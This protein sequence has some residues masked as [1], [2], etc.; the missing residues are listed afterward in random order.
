MR[1][2][3]QRDEFGKFLKG[4]G[5]GAS[6]RRK[7]PRRNRK[8]TAKAGA[9]WPKAKEETFFRELAMVC[10]VSSAWRKAG[11]KGS[12]SL[13]YDRRKLDS[14]FRAM[15]AD[16]IDQSYAMLELEMLERSRFGVDRPA[17]A[18]E[19]EK[20]LREIPNGLALQLLKLH[21]NRKASQA[22]ATPARAAKP[23]LTGRAL[24]LEV[25]RRFSEIN[26]RM[27]G[28]G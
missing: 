27:G 10:N 24:R 4:G 13:A 26:R 21:Q 9:K 20:R 19:A 8:A 23:R 15:W 12:S 2:E 22:A 7:P 1:G 14:R 5:A 6:E 28:N 18:T 17:P 3:R 16:A 25:I 11:L